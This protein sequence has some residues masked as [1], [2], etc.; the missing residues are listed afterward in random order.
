M[1]DLSKMQTSTARQKLIDT[2][3]TLLAGFNYVPT[4][5]APKLARV[6]VEGLGLV[7]IDPELVDAYRKAKEA[8]NAARAEDDQMH[9]YAVNDMP[10]TMLDRNN[11]ATSIAEKVLA[12]LEGKLDAG[13]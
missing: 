5:E 8:D 12:Q 9:R 10:E 7:A 3:A 4:E 2:L 13:T 11:Y 1:S 6:L